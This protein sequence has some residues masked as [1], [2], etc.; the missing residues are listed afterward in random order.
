MNKRFPKKE[1]C[2]IYLIVPPTCSRGL[3]MMVLN[4]L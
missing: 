2:V 3:G 4:T 1:V